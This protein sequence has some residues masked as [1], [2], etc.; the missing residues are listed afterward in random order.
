[1][2]GFLV[3]KKSVISTEGFAVSAKPWWRP[4]F[5]FPKNNGADSCVRAAAFAFAV[6]SLRNAPCSWLLPVNPAQCAMLLV[7]ACESGTMRH[8]P[9]CCL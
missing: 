4:A 3:L 9:D 1:M 2:T 6:G 8:A 5:S 7:V